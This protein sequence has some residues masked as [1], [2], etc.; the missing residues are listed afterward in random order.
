MPPKVKFSKEKIAT[1]A[2]EM[3]RK[4]GIDFLS[5]RSLAAE[6]G[7]STAPIFT[8]FQSIEEVQ[9]SVI[10]MAKE[11]Y[12]SYINQALSSELPFKESGMQYIR[13]AAEEPELF[14][15]LFMR[16]SES[17]QY[18]HFFP[19]GDENANAILDIITNNHGISFDKAKKLY[20][21]LSVYVHGIAVLFAQKQF[22]F[23]MDDVSEMLSEVFNALIREDE[24]E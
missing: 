24:N 20:N 21:H 19:S 8:S 4:H 14:K 2:F 1:V 3:V 15:L 22:V 7:S 5:A 18:S 11:L 23:T 12:N 9:R 13:L 16:G 10:D 6:L 17:E